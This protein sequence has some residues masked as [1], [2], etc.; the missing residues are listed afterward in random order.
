MN[1]R[2]A[3]EAAVKYRL[4]AIRDMTKYFELIIHEATDE[5]EATDDI[6]VKEHIVNKLQTRI[7]NEVDMISQRTT[8]YIKA[9]YSKK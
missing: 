3:R 6:T 2:E 7:Q 5:F 1:N 4:L 8:D 9:F